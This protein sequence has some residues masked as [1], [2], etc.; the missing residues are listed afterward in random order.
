MMPSFLL[1]YSFFTTRKNVTD[2]EIVSAKFTDMPAKTLEVPDLGAQKAKA[3]YGL[4][5][6]DKPGFVTSPYSP[7]AGSIDVRGIPKDTEVKDPHSGK[8]FLVP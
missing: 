5:V 4:P 7:T 8:I 3:Q 6:G 1:T 2:V